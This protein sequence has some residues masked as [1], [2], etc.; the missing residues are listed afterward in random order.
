MID[1]VLVSLMLCLM[2]LCAQIV[3]SHTAYH[4]TYVSGNLFHCQLTT[5]YNTPM[6]LFIANDNGWRVMVNDDDIVISLQKLGG[7]LGQ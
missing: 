7:I 4:K 6:Q 3:C 2:K 1:V 5:F